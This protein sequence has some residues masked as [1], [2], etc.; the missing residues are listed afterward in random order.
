MMTECPH[1]HTAVFPSRDGICP[2][3]L[4]DVFDLSGVDP[5]KTTVI[6]GSNSEMPSVCCSCGVYTRRFVKVKGYSAIKVEGSAANET[7]TVL[8]ILAGLLIP[9]VG[10]VLSA[11]RGGSVRGKH[12][13]HKIV[14][15]VP[16]CKAC[17]GNRI[18]PISVDRQSVRMKL[19]VDNRFEKFFREANTQ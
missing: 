5:T 11:G 8:G 4:K 18:E 13:L 15:R 17:S 16:Q 9:F 6:V 12:A 19:L 14:V 1:C 10:L 3:C 7:T 2:A